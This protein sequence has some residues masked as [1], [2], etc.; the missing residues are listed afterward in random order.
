[1][2][3]PRIRLLQRQEKTYLQCNWI[4]SKGKPGAIGRW[5]GFGP[6]ATKTFWRFLKAYPRV[7]RNMPESSS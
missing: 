6:S 3:K 4:D 7:R 2:I 1:M 5:S